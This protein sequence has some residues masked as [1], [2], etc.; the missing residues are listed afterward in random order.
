[1]PNN[2][3]PSWIEPPPKSNGL[4]CLGKGCLFAAF[5]GVL[6]LFGIFFATRAVVSK[7]PT[8]L[9][10]EPLP[11]QELSDVRQRIDEFKSNVPVPSFTPTPAATGAP[12]PAESVTPVPAA[13][14]T[15]RQL[16]L[17][18]SEINGLIAANSKS[19]GHASV[20]LSGNT[21]QVQLSIPLKKVPG[22]SGDYLNGSFVITTNGPTPINGLQVSRI[23]T[24]G[25]PMPS[26]IL[27]TNVGGQ[28]V[29]GLALDQAARY[30]VS[31]AEIRDGVVILR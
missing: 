15:S 11:E 27:S 12:L 29:I 22:M 26:S 25:Y 6:V 1:M 8:V 7:K 13:T 18:A 23:R 16:T 21:A 30:H 17:S 5:I 10:V 3:N 31:T 4:G 9:S 19:R 28:S 20:S 14:P 24:N 2:P